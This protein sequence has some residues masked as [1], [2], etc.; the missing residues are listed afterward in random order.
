MPHVRAAHARLT[1][2]VQTLR[3]T[4]PADIPRAHHGRTTDAP[5]ATR[6]HSIN[7]TPHYTSRTSHARPKKTLVGC[8][9]SGRGVAVSWPWDDLWGVRRVPVESARGDR[10]VSSA[11]LCAW[12]SVCLICGARWTSVVCPWGVQ[13]VPIGCP[14]GVPGMCVAC[15]WIACKRVH[16]MLEQISIRERSFWR[17]DLPMGYNAHERSM[18]AHQHPR[19]ARWTSHRG[20]GHATDTPWSPHGPT[21][22]PRAFHGLSR[23]PHGEHTGFSLTRHPMDTQHIPHGGAIDRWTPHGLPENIPRALHGHTTDDPCTLDG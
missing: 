6:R 1:C 21:A 20:K 4:H 15:P 10:G 8:P 2:N 19:D 13:S 22:T 9:R 5:R 11:G 7:T 18:D 16:E 17:L 23:A 3:Y 12:V 14:W